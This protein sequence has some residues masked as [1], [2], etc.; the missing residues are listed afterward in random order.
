M[1]PSVET[2]TMTWGTLLLAVLGGYLLA[3][4]TFLLFTTS[5]HNGNNAEAEERYHWR[6]SRYSSSRSRGVEE[7]IEEAEVDE[8]TMNSAVTCIVLF[9]ILLTIAFEKAK[10]YI[11]HAAD[12]NLKPTIEAIFGEMTV[13]GFV[14]AI[15]FTL[16]QLGVFSILS[17]NLFHEDDILLELFEF[18][19]YFLFLIM[20]FFVGFVLLLV[21]E[22]SH[23]EHEWRK[24]DK[25]CNDTVYMSKLILENND[26]IGI[27]SAPSKNWLT[28]LYKS[29]LA[30][31]SFQFEEDLQLF[32]GLRQDFLH[33]RGSEEPFSPAENRV[34]GN[35]NF[36]GYLNVCLG[37][38]LENI[39]EVYPITW[40]CFIGLTICYYCLLCLSSSDTW[41]S[42]RSGGDAGLCRWGGGA[43]SRLSMLLIFLVHTDFCLDMG[44]RWLG[45]VLFWKLL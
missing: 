13:L 33:E 43:P 7:E 16:S 15:S 44:T 17:E 42:V 2:A 22:A 19:H 40:F 35:F 18:V 5:H 6:V 27:K 12:R 34:N 3:V 37:H 31:K 20:I 39:V 32:H 28:Y 38:T 26:K 25:A 21:R 45:N 10:Q 1:T 8:F 24:M 29:L 4:A 14:S 30:R 41:V 9:L 23:M 11:L 36:G